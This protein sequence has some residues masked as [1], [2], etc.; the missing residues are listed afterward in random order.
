VVASHVLTAFD[1]DARRT[2]LLKHDHL[3][4]GDA[5][6]IA[7]CNAVHTFFMKFPIDVAFVTRD[8]RVIKIRSRVAP[9]RIAASLRAYAVIE[10]AA[11]TLERTDT[12]RGDRLEVKDRRDQVNRGA[13]SPTASP[14]S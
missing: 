14:A 10:L 4:E 5:L 7:P 12:A 9:W 8:G 1:S 13:E 3:P 2:G 11:G 6:V